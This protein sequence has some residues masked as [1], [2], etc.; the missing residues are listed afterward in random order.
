MANTAVSWPGRL[1]QIHSFFRARSPDEML[2]TAAPWTSPWLPPGYEQN[3]WNAALA[4]ARGIGSCWHEAH[5]LAGLG[6]ADLA[7][8]RA[9]QAET[10]L[11]Q[12]QAIF[13]RIGAAEA[14]SVTAK[15]QE[16]HAKFTAESMEPSAGM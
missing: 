4:L 11:R 14:A 15:L 12:A 13:Q 1:R 3:F 6:C 2:A 7:A 8:D 10:D 5:A 9:T 16:M